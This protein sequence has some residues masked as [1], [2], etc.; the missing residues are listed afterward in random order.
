MLI[1]ISRDQWE[2]VPEKQ[3]LKHLAFAA[4]NCRVVNEPVYLADCFRKQTVFKWFLENMLVLMK[5][6]HKKYLIQVR[7]GLFPLGNS[8][9]SDH[10][11]LFCM[12]ILWSLALM[13]SQACTFVAQQP[14]AFA[15]VPSKSLHFAFSVPLYPPSPVA[16]PRVN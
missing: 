14:H 16:N 4:S 10:S 12:H 3:K 13:V 15:F 5:S 11:M 7:A 2:V 9:N 6:V 8:K 1:K